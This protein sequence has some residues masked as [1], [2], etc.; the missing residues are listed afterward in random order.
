MSVTKTPCGSI[1]LCGSSCPGKRKLMPDSE[2]VADSYFEDK[3]LF[4]PVRKKRALSCHPVSMAYHS[5]NAKRAPY[6][7]RLLPM[8]KVSVT[9]RGRQGIAQQHPELRDALMDKIWSLWACGL[10]WHSTLFCP[11]ATAVV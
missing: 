4:P 5:T 6:W 3:S 11:S 1:W 7:N 10:S 2:V 9:C 8:A